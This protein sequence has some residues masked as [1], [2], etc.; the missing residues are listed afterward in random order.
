VA[1]TFVAETR[2]E[3][4]P[5]FL[6]DALGIL[7]REA[8]AQLAAV[9][10]RL[11]PRHAVIRAGTSAPLGLCLL[12]DP[13]WVNQSADGEVELALDEPTLAAL[14]TGEL[15]LEEGIVAGTFHARGAVDDLLA[16]LDALASWLHGA[17][18]C[19]SLPELQRAYL[20]IGRKGSL[21]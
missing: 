3:A 13:P 4:L 19:P 21:P 5:R 9:R 1:E 11:G 20:A 10:E 15:T 14:L 12:G 2:A 7:A 8:P 6:E 17:M 18:R 16:F